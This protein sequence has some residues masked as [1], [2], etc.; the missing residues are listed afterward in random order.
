M[1]K[2]I[3]QMADGKGFGKVLAQGVRQAAQ[4]IGRGAENYAAHIKGLEMAG[5]HPYNM[6]GTALGYSVSSRGADFSDIYATLE[7]KWLPEKATKVLISS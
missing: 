1:E 3:R 2:L 7:Y 5:Y 4:I 6:M